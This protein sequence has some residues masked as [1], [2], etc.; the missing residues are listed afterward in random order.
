[1]DGVLDGWRTKDMEDYMTYEMDC[2]TELENDMEIAIA[3]MIGW[4]ELE[5]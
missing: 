2:Y 4:M 5:S 3:D 1:M